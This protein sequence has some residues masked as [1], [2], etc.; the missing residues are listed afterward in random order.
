[1]NARGYVPAMKE[2]RLHLGCGLNTPE[3]WI[4]LD[5]S[6]NARLAKHSTL[7][8]FLKAFHVLPA[9]LLE[10]PWSPDILNH[11]VRNPLPF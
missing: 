2:K 10:V 4:N 8:R 6:W 3:G 7:R 5:G 11:D 1:M 9:S